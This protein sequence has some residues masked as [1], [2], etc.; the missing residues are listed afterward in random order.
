MLPLPVVPHNPTKYRQVP[1]ARG[2]VVLRVRTLY[3]SSSV[4]TARYYTQYLAQAPGEVPG[5][6][7]GRQATALGLSGTVEADDL[8]VLLEG[9][10]PTTGMS[11]G[12]RLVD[13]QT[14]ERA[15]RSGR[16]PGLMRRSRRRSR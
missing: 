3:A 5:E 16:W 15:R 7:T 1:G 2:R 12:N 11:L 10:D 8:Q 14:S 13:R 4:A 6:W 9:R